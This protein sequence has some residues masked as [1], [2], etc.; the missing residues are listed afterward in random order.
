MKEVNPLNQK[1]ETKENK[2]IGWKT[3][4]GIL[5]EPDKNGKWPAVSTTSDGK[6]II[7]GGNSDLGLPDLV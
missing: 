7:A 4:E 1:L 2:T 5:I 3:P 6:T